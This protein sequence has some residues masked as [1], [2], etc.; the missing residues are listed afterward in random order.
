MQLSHEPCRRWKITFVFLRTRYNY[1]FSDSSKSTKSRTTKTTW[2]NVSY[3]Y[4]FFFIAVQ[5]INGMRN[6]EITHLPARRST[7]VNTKLNSESSI[8]SCNPWTQM[9]NSVVHCMRIC[10]IRALPQSIW[11]GSMTF[12]KIKSRAIKKNEREKMQLGKRKTVYISISIAINIIVN[13]FSL[14]H[15]VYDEIFFI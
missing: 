8:F 10:S 7:R 13:G 14:H 5:L 2:I 1:G 9:L 3:L 15:S 11:F 6:F 12:W 4:W